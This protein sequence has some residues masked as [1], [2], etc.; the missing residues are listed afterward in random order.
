[1]SDGNIGWI[2]TGRHEKSTSLQWRRRVEK[3]NGIQKTGGKKKGKTNEKVTNTKR[4]VVNPE[5]SMCM[6]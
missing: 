3:S 1:M 2:I 6:E 5:R 4:R